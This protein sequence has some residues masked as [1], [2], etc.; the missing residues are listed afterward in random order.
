[1]S[2]FSEE[3]ELKK[4]EEKT[5]A[6]DGKGR[7]RGGDNARQTDPTDRGRPRHSAMHSLTDREG[8]IALC[9]YIFIL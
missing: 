3:K 5:A 6:D 2:P 1:M 9:R 8:G 4:G 7:E